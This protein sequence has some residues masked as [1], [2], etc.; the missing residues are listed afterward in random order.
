M[1]RTLAA[2]LV[3]LLTMFLLPS[4]GTFTT[5]NSQFEE[6]ELFRGQPNA[7]PY[8]SAIA[9]Y[10]RIIEAMTNDFET[11]D[12]KQRGFYRMPERAHYSWDQDL[13]PTVG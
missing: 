10:Y 11:D 4:C 6:N 12:G 5:W 2:C 3:C 7:D 9:R 13:P 1:K 8:L